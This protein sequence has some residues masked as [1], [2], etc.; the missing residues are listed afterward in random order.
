[1]EIDRLVNVDP[2]RAWSDEAGNFT[3][4]L[5]AHLD[6]LGEVIGIPLEVTGTEV[7]VEGFSA[8]ILARNPDDG[9][10]VLIENQLEATDHRHLGQILTCLAGLEAKTVIWLATC[11]REPHLSA[12]KW[13]NDHTAE[14]FN[15]FAILLRVVRIGESPVAP[16]FEVLARPNRWEK[17]LQA[18][19]RSS[20]ERSEIGAFREAFWTAYLVRFPAD[21]SL[22]V[23]ATGA[24]SVWLPVDPDGTVNVS[25]WV[26]KTQVGVFVRGLRGS[27]GS[28][29]AELLEPHRQFLERELGANYGRTTGAYFFNRVARFEMSDREKWP[30]AVD[31]LHKAVANYLKTLR[32]ILPE[33][34]TNSAESLEKP[35]ATIE[36]AWFDGAED[37]LAAYDRGVIASVMLDEMIAAQKSL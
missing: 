7:P 27:D 24:S 15:F 6:Q 23:N 32:E 11:F 34:A 3:P 5:A 20:L 13:L 16:I 22:G 9:S 30:A 28:E 37:R 17:R 25:L 14:D 4:W 8:D 29:L 35:D 18:T 36:E 1:M 12:V 33:T 31:W 10:L 2:R 19:A 26:G 21:E